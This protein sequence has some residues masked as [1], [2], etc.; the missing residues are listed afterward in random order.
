MTIVVDASVA[1]KWVIPEVL[2]DQANSLRGRTDR[3]LAPDPPA[4]RGGERP[5]EEADATRDHRAGGGP[6]HRSPDGQ[7]ARSQAVWSIT[8]PGA[9]TGSAIAPS[10][11]RLPLR[12]AGAS[13][14]RHPDH[15]RSPL[16]RARHEGAGARRRDEPGHAVRAGQSPAVGRFFVLLATRPGG[17]QRSLLGRPRRP[18]SRR[19]S[20]WSGAIWR[21]RRY[22]CAAAARS[23]ALTAARARPSLASMLPGS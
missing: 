9:H 13:R 1:V 11:L 15:R 18:S 8:G 2:S 7:R 5:V 21:T 19:A 23:P 6:G 3:L 22:S 17:A 4:P 20:G 14:G 10:R 12:G 16:A